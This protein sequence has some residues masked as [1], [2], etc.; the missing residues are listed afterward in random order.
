MKVTVEIDHE[1]V[2]IAR[3]PIYS[4]AAALA[5]LSVT[6]APLF[7]YLSGKGEFYPGYEWIIVPAVFWSDLFR[8]F[9]LL[10]PRQYSGQG[11]KAKFEVAHYHLA[12]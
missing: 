6:F 11:T 1:W 2:R 3:S 12:K 4:I 7:L 8:S 5:S 9:V 10:S